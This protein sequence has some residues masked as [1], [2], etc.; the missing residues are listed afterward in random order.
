ME[1]KGRQIFSKIVRAS[2]L[3]RQ[4]TLQINNAHL[5]NL[6]KLECA[7]ILNFIEQLVTSDRSL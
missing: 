2:K 1:K 7:F 5:E 6:L 3:T 4:R